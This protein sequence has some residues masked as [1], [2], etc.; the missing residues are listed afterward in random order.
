MKVNVTGP[1]GIIEETQS[2]GSYNKI[3][4][5]RC[6]VYSSKGPIPI[7][8]VYDTV[9]LL[10]EYKVGDKVSIFCILEGREWTKPGTSKKQYLLSLRGVSI[11][12]Q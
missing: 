9:T 6:V 10:D 3:H 12:R 1:L 2:V 8:F 4:K 5:R 7:D 11:T